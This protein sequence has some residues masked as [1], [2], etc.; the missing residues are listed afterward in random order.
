MALSNIGNE[1]RREITEH[2]AGIILIVGTLGVTYAG[3]CWFFS[4][5]NIGET[6][7]AMM[8]TALGGVIAIG[9]MTVF[10]HAVGEIACDVLDNLG[11][12]PRPKQRYR[13]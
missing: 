11:L 10:I 5:K 9:F 2:A 6:V 1:P 7:L 12:D 4:P 8:L 3:A 13:R